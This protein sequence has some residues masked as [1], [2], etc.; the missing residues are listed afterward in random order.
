MDAN[1]IIKHKPAGNHEKIYQDAKEFSLYFKQ[2][3]GYSDT[4]HT[5]RNSTDRG[6]ATDSIYEIECF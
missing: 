2:G 6:L 4:N 3:C 5:I 1:Q